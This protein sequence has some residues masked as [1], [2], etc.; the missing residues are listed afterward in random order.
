MCWYAYGEPF[1]PHEIMEKMMVES[2]SSA[3]NMHGVKTN[4]INPY[5]TMVMDVMRMNQG[6]TSQ[7]SIVDKEPNANAI[8]YFDLLKDSNELLWDGCINHSKLSIV[9]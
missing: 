6:H 4:N 1:V 7:C 2:T 8:R 3:I 5:K 9:A